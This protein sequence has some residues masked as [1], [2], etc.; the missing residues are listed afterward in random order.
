LAYRNAQRK[1]THELLEGLPVIPR[2]TSFI[3]ENCWRNGFTSHYQRPEVVI[4]D[5][6]AHKYGSKNEKRWQD[7]LRFW[8]GINVISAVN[9]QH[10]ESLNE[11]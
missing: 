1:E 7:V 11:M 10:L 3:K 2:R 4:V 5:E 6:L 8:R 9:I